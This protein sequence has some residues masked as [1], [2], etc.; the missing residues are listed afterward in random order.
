MANSLTLTINPVTL[1]TLSEVSLSATTVAAIDN[2]IAANTP[3]G[4]DYQWQRRQDT[5]QWSNISLANDTSHITTSA[6]N[7]HYL[8]LEII[9]KDGATALNPR[10]TNQT[11]KVNT[12]TSAALETLALDYSTN[13]KEYR[14]SERSTL[15]LDQYLT[16]NALSIQGYQWYRM[17]V[18]GDFANNS[19]AINAAINASYVLEP[20]SDVGFEHLLVISL[21]NNVDVYSER[22]AEWQNNNSDPTE[23]NQNE[24]YFDVVSIIDGTTPLQSGQT[25]TAQLSG[26]SLVKDT[27][28]PGASY[29]WQSRAVGTSGTWN[30]IGLDSRFLYANG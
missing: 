13:L 28:P 1:T 19:E 23:I 25:V 5:T 4:V 9:L 12:N 8:R 17:P 20:S 14:L 22:T 21:N 7:N 3:L 6:D 24:R 26:S 2:A 15:W 16:N 18:G 11:N 30:N 27:L 10:F 29:Q